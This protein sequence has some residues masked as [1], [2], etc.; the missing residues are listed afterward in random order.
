METVNSQMTDDGEDVQVPNVTHVDSIIAGG[1]AS[2]ITKD[3][4]NS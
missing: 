3:L 4:G 1:E 2:I